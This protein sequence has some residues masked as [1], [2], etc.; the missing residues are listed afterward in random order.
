MRSEKN[1][2][3]DRMWAQ[4]VFGRVF[5]L[6]RK[7]SFWLQPAHQN[8]GTD[9][10]WSQ[11]QFLHAQHKIVATLARLTWWVVSEW[12]SK[13]GTGTTGTKDELEL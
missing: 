11:L 13:T 6:H 3:W 1:E 12:P 9:R 7:K 10:H 5:E 2:I 8:V 4:I